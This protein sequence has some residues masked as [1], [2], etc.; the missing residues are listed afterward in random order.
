M[1]QASLIS[2]GLG[3]LSARKQRKQAARQAA[4]DRE[5]QREQAE[6]LEKE[7]QWLLFSRNKIVWVVGR[8]CDERFIA[9]EQTKNKLLLRLTK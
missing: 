4:Q 1:W 9:N 3:F 6:L 8:R 7:K 5:F 2:A